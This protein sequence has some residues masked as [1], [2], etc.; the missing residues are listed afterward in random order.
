MQTQIDL[1]NIGDLEDRRVT[2]RDHLASA[3]V[4]PWT[5]AIVRL[6][7]GR[8]FDGNNCE[9]CWLVGE[10]MVDA[11]GDY[12]PDLQFLRLAVGPGQELRTSLKDVRAI[13]LA[14]A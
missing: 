12:L 7:D 9:L 10:P 13:L 2:V 1:S 11:E 5:R 6:D 14:N 4:Q 8:S 3:N